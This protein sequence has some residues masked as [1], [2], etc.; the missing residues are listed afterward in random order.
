TSSGLGELF[1]IYSSAMLIFAGII[2]LWIII[3]AVAETARTGIP[4]GKQFNHVWAPIRLV[5]ALGL[6]IPLGSGLNSG[7]HLVIYLTQWGSEQANMMWVTFADKTAI[8]GS[9]GNNTGGNSQI[10]GALS[11]VPVTQDSYKSIS[12]KLFDIL[13]CQSIYNK[14]AGT[15]SLSF[16]PDPSGSVLTTA[17]NAT[18]IDVNGNQSAPTS[19]NYQVRQF[20][21][22]VPG[23]LNCG[24][25]NFPELKPNANGQNASA[26]GITAEQVLAEQSSQLTQF[27]NL[28]RA[29]AEKV[30]QAAV[31]AQNSQH[32]SFGKMDLPMLDFYSNYQNIANA[33]AAARTNSIRTALSSYNGLLGLNFQSEAKTRGWISA[34][35]WLNRIAEQNG[36]VLD[37]ASVFPNIESPP[38]SGL[39]LTASNNGGLS[40][41][42]AGDIQGTWNIAQ[43]FL[44]KARQLSPAPAQTDPL[45]SATEL[46]RATF[47]EILKPNSNPLGTIGGFGR[48]LMTQ[49]VDIAFNSAKGLKE[50]GSVQTCGDA[51]GTCD[52]NGPNTSPTA[53]LLQ[54]F[55]AAMKKDN[56]DGNPATWGVG[57]SGA[58]ANAALTNDFANQFNQMPASVMR[59]VGTMLISFGFMAGYVL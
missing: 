4:F 22:Q 14:I 45:G 40:E 32:P 50:D 21:W 56:A 46:M 31:N 52:V 34:P 19:S 44:G 51:L 3:S 16:M 54:K 13:L 41:Q 43:T 38:V 49:G 28:A 48:N 39:P 27:M 33:Y 9:S 26:A 25:A 10:P 30:A 36:R 47:G 42:V 59:P 58:A 6:L 37:V 24:S 12:D 1:R 15:Q 18:I 55:D 20:N 5:V 23:E 7:Q 29:E 11:A 53:L 57:T 17:P 35:V 2:V 8:S